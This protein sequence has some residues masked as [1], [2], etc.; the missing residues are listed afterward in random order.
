LDDKRLDTCRSEAF[1]HIRSR[2]EP[3]EVDLHRFALEI[4]PPDCVDDPIGKA[5]QVGDE[6]VHRWGSG[7][8]EGGQ[9]DGGLCREGGVERSF[10]VFAQWTRV[11]VTELQIAQTV[12]QDQHV[13]RAGRDGG[14]Q[15][16]IQERGDVISPQTV[17]KF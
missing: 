11:G 17:F 14:G 10:A 16:G 15:I 6:A 12:E 1:R 4:E 3:R 5:E 7:G 9:V 8:G 13:C 2:E